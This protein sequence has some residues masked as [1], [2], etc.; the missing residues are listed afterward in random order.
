MGHNNLH[1][2]W[3]I[4]GDMSKVLDIENRSFEHPWCEEEFLSFLT[5]RNCIG[6]VAE[7]NDYREVMGFMFYELHKGELRIA[8][9]AVDPNYRRQGGG[10]IM[11]DKLKGKLYR[12]RREEL[13]LDIRES[14]LEGQLFFKSQG[15]KAMSVLRNYYED[16]T[17]D[18]Y[19]MVYSITESVPSNSIYEHAPHNRISKYTQGF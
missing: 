11:L 16:T 1:V 4:R 8:N 13:T 10:I 2:R 3:M 6:M 18:A 12:Q 14:N 15:F 7:N 17:E 5:Q 19:N 9:F